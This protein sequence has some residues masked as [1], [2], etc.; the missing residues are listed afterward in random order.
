MA[1]SMP[2]IVVMTLVIIGAMI[3]LTRRVD[4]QMS[5][6]LG[7]DTLSDQIDFNGTPVQ[8]VED[9]FA[10]S[11]STGPA[12]MDEV[13]T[14][15]ESTGPAPMDEVFTASEST[16][17]APMDEVFTAS[18]STGPAPMDKDAPTTLDQLLAIL[19]ATNNPDG[20]PVTLDDRVEI[21][22]EVVDAIDKIETYNA[23]L[24]ID[25][26]ATSVLTD[27][28]EQKE[29]LM[30]IL[31]NATT[32]DYLNE[33]FDQIDLDQVATLEMRMANLE[34]ERA[35]LEAVKE[36][37]FRAQKAEVQRQLDDI[38]EQRRIEEQRE[39][40]EKAKRLA[41]HQT[42]L[43]LYETEKE[44][45]Q[46]VRSDLLQKLSA[47][48]IDEG[49]LKAA[50]LATQTRVNLAKEL[51][52]VRLENELLKLDDMEDTTEADA[53]R[54]KL[55]SDSAAFVAALETE[56]KDANDKLDKSIRDRTELLGDLEDLEDLIQRDVDDA[57][58]LDDTHL[59]NEQDR[60]AAI[61]SDRLTKKAESDALLSINEEIERE[62]DN[63]MSDL[64]DATDDEI[65]RLEDARDALYQDIQDR[66]DANDEILSDAK[67]AIAKLDEDERFATENQLKTSKA[68]IGAEAAMRRGSDLTMFMASNATYTTQHRIILDQVNNDT[69]SIAAKES[70]PE[71]YEKLSTCRD[72]VSERNEE[73]YRTAM[74]K[75][76]DHEYKMALGFDITPEEHDAL[77]AVE[78]Y[79]SLV[80]IEIL[81]AKHRDLATITGIEKVIIPEDERR[82]TQTGTNWMY[83]GNP[84]DVTGIFFTAFGEHIGNDIPE[85][86]KLDLVAMGYS[87]YDTSKFYE[88]QTL[89]L[90]KFGISVYQGDKNRYA[91]GITDAYFEMNVF[92]PENVIIACAAESQMMTTCVS[93]LN[94][95]GT[96]MTEDEKEQ[97]G[98]SVMMDEMVVSCK[99]DPTTKPIEP[100]DCY[101]TWDLSDCKNPPV[102]WIRD[103][104]FD[105]GDKTAT[106]E[107]PAMFGGKCDY[108]D[109]QKVKCE[110]GDKD[111]EARQELDGMRMATASFL[112]L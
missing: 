88:D 54:A 60:L 45:K 90:E 49:K 56:I 47:Y 33:E 9:I 73:L 39:A 37:E 15:S 101:V 32:Q 61:E 18:E 86:L 59:S 83:D 112:G 85:M 72:E 107:Y 3:I 8:E 46:S 81:P 1:M 48:E 53:L 12:P 67:D 5:D 102:A 52:S 93:E 104:F 75:I 105:Y 40:T 38:A 13:F 14:A 43:A 50:A 91:N 71:Q 19:Q 77:K 66:K 55:E 87:E 58:D 70:C 103:A 69:I 82:F 35:A 24:L 2:M 109:G 99:S 17:P 76:T 36:E 41:A 57:N 110:Y 65:S 106:V 16:G 20:T 78:M 97:L 4:I 42:A 95:D 79:K 100:M 10:A 63:I 22:K 25:E 74:K 44:K 80:G 27:I 7:Q 96:F 92:G 6:D 84:V 34:T 62:H 30:P 111:S 94:E 29:Q 11:E 51:E 26:Q 23:T 89:N 64:R 68:V 108:T 21:G 98:R 31:R 28:A